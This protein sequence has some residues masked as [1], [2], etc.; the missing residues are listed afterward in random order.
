MPPKGKGDGKKEGKGGKTKPNL[1]IEFHADLDLKKL[2]DNISKAKVPMEPLATFTKK[3]K[4]EYQG[5]KDNEILDIPTFP[6]FVTE[7]MGFDTTKCIFGLLEVYPWLKQISLFHCKIGDDGVMVI[8]D[9]LKMYKPPADRNPFGITILELP[10]NDITEKGALY[11]GRVLTHNETVTTLNLDFNPIGDEGAAALGEG[12][13]WNSTLEN[14]SMKYCSIGPIGGECV[15]TLIVRSSS[16]RELYLRGNQ[17]GPHGVIHIARA[18]SK[19]AYLTKIDLAD[20]G[21]GIDLEAIE[22]LRDGF[23]SNDSLETVDLKMNSM[24][25]TGVQLLLEMLKAKPKLTR[26]EVSER[27][28]DAVF[29]DILDT[30]ANND[31]IMKNKRKKG[32]KKKAAK[33]KG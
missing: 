21:F 22:A 5:I 24:V 10:E 7:P 2:G 12:L 13:K 6:L 16:V 3:V 9:F 28:S 15:G 14:L 11:L 26:F 31:K 4:A 25:P 17:I 23:E 19:N 18:L 29:R 30:V 33:K 20:T 27:I 8:A 32:G 1:A